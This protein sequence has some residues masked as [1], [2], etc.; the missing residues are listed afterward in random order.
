MKNLTV[1]REAV[2][3]NYRKTGKEGR[4]I[5]EA[6]FGREQLT[7]NI[8][9]RVKTFEDACEL[10]SHDGTVTGTPD[11]VAYKQLKV[12]AEALNEGWTP[13][14]EGDEYKWYPGFN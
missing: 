2:I 11:E 6:L 3:A 5:L 1:E 4:S 10:L 13:D 12:I 7:I 9:E 14:W 8:T